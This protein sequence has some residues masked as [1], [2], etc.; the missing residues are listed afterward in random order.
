MGFAYANKR[1]PFAFLIVC[2]RRG[3]SH[4]CCGGMETMGGNFV[5]F[6]YLGGCW[7]KQN[8]GFLSGFWDELLFS[9]TYDKREVLEFSVFVL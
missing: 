8:F 5:D 6:L 2:V 7:K 4:A 9:G 1:S 3:G